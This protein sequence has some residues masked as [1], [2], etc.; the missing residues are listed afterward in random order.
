[1]ASSQEVTGRTVT[2]RSL[3]SSVLVGVGLAAT[4]IVF[5]II[6]VA[7]FGAAITWW[8]VKFNHSLDQVRRDQR[9][10]AAEIRPIVEAHRRGDGG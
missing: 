4:G 1:M 10:L 5:G 2:A 8:M 3:V 9:A 7:V 6:V